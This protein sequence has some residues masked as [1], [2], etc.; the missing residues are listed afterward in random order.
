M[1]QRIV[2][3]A[4]LKGMR[5]MAVMTMVCL[6]AFAAER[7]GLD[8]YAANEFGDAVHHLRSVVEGGEASAE[9]VKAY[10]VS[11]LRTGQNAEAET[12]LRA[13]LEKHGND[14]GLVLALSEVLA[15]E[16]KFGEAR[17]MLAKGRELDAEHAW[18]PYV[19]GVIEAGEKNFAK[20]ASLL[21]AACAKDQRNAYAHY[22][23]GLSYNSVR[24]P[25]KMVGH[26]QAFLKLAPKAPEAARV[27]S[28]LRTVR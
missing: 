28:I 1:T 5:W 26:F 21:E 11:L 10:G 9:V 19:E 14:A 13:G 2:H 24:R 20:A 12:V 23:A 6:S 22:Y 16:K 7:Q 17:E 27:Q 18:A 3:A 15:H 25:D 4:K 8:H